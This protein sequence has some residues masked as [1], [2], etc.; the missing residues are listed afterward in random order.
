MTI[1][2]ND[3][4]RELDAI[5]LHSLTRLVPSGRPPF[6]VRVSMYLDQEFF[7]QPLRKKLS[8]LALASNWV[9]QK[10]HGKVFRRA[11]QLRHRVAPTIST[12]RVAVHG[13]GSIGDFL[14]HMLCIQEFC[15]AYGPAQIDFYTH[16]KKVDEARFIFAQSRFVRKVLSAQYLPVLRSNYDLVVRDQ[17]IV[18][19]EV[20]NSQRIFELAPQL[21]NVVAQAQER[22]EPYEFMFNNHPQLDGMFSRGV[23]FDKMNVA[24]AIGYFTGLDV[25]RD[26]IP[27]FCADIDRYDVLQRYGLNGRHY[28]TVHDGFDRSYVPS[29]ETAT[30]CWPIEYWRRFVALMKQEGDVMIVQVGAKNSRPIEGVD[31]DLTNQTTLDEVSWI[32]KHALLHVD[33]ES[34]LVRLAHALHTNAV[35]LF[36]PTSV[37]FFGLQGNTNV[38][39][40]GCNNCWWST[41][42]WLSVC[43]RGFARP[44]CMDAISPE[45]VRDAVMGHLHR[46][47][48]PRFEIEAT[49]IYESETLS[50]DA[51]KLKELFT[52]TG[53]SSVPITQHTKNLDSGVY[54][55]ASKQWEYLQA[56]R[57]VASM[58]AELSRPLRIADVGGGRGALAPYLA[59]KGH[60]IEVF[61][62]DYLWD[63]GGDLGI[64]WRFRR[65]A[66][67][68]RLRVRYGSLFN[69]PARSGDYDLVISTSVIEHVRHKE[70]ALKELLRL[71]RPGGKLFMSF[72]L[73][74]DGAGK[75]DRMRVEVASPK[76][77]REALA[78]IEGSGELFSAD[79]IKDSG[80]RIQADGVCGIPQG[81][82]VAACTIVR[83]D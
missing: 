21:L 81:M 45:R 29:G 19:Y 22:F 74:E 50:K 30:K 26:S 12:L 73:T 16:P 77:L 36:G 41:P 34:G 62:I 46:S 54:L 38:V 65:W 49:A 57:V 42:N 6:I 69:V 53:L 32:L 35:V 61:D 72:D 2:D 60:Q 51:G 44:Q 71:L 13:S 47:L 70:Y 28:I 9:I 24:E 33:G 20:V 76:R 4:R 40:E 58:E 56:L 63:H 3:A 79:A 15:R 78:G 48:R 66:E 18:K 14:G 75:E 64:E 23:H 82:T 59:M 7:G 80:K 1:A 11:L 10:V 5:Q 37:S 43:P 68:R 8:F 39:A 17:Y 31:L 25:N 52:A 55:H 67:G 27:Y 83:C